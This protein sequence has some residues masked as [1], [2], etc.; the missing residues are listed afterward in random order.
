MEKTN[1]LSDGKNTLKEMTHGNL[2]RIYKMQAKNYRNIFRV[3]HNQDNFSTE[4]KLRERI[5]SQTSFGHISIDSSMILMG[6]MAMESSQKDL[7][8][9]AN[10]IL[11]QSILAEI[12]DRSTGNYYGTVYSIANISE[13]TTINDLVLDSS[14]A[15]FILLKMSLKRPQGN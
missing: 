2:K 10:H 3:Y 1:T 5:I 14:E 7:L 9:N 6:L 12:L 15:L 11:R 13:T 8:I 4:L